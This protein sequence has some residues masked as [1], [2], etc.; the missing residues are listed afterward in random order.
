MKKIKGI[1]NPYE[2]LSQEVAVERLQQWI[3]EMNAAHEKRWMEKRDYERKFK[4]IW[5]KHYG[6]YGLKCREFEGIRAYSNF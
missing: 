1:I 4:A 3:K 2:S 5:N 6:S